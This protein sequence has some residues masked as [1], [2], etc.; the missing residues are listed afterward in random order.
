VHELVEP[1]LKRSGIP[2]KKSSIPIHHYGKLNQQKSD[3]KRETYYAI[4]RKKLAEMGDDA[5]ALRELAIQAEILGK[6]DESL[7]LWERFLAVSPGDP[8]AYINMG[9]AHGRRGEFAALLETAEKALALKPGL[10]EAHYNFALAKLHLARAAEA[11]DALED[12]LVQVGEYPPAQFLLAAA[13]SLSERKAEAMQLLQ[14]LRQSV[15]GPSLAA[16]CRELA[17]GFADT[18]ETGMALAL[19]ET[20]VDSGLQSK[21][22]LD[23]YS[24]C[25][26]SSEDGNPSSGDGNPQNKGLSKR[27]SRS[28]TATHPVTGTRVSI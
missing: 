4:G 24:H 2:M 16:R 5:V 28:A 15:I 1:S 14:Q 18:G 12:L 10:K 17:Q 7:E 26:K 21:E 25:L 19:L 11:A 3:E 23:V 8:Q 27:I 6:H 9:I 20:V 22:L 13:Y